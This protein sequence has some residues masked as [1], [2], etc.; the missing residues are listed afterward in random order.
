MKDIFY[1]PQKAKIIARI[2]S[3]IRRLVTGEMADK[4]MFVELKEALSFLERETLKD[5]SLINFE[6][7]LVSRILRSLGYWPK[8]SVDFCWSKESVDGLKQKD[9]VV[10]LINR[11]L[12]HSQL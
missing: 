4:E 1:I 10:S 7:I 11:S 5:E 2:F 6:V 12:S 3:L 8:P 9:K